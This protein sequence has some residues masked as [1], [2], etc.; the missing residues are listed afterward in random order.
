MAQLKKDKHKLVLTADKGVALAVMDKEDYIRKAEE[1]LEQPA[2][3]TIDRDPANKIKAT[4]ITKLRKI[5]KETRL[6]EGTYKIMYPIG[7]VPTSFMGYQKS[8]KMAPPQ[9]NCF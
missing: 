6:D 5:K 8:I 3:R 2:Y 1:L 7:C 9:D 4:L